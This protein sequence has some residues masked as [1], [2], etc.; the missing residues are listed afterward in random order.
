VAA[1]DQAEAAGGA[2]PAAPVSD[3]LAMEMAQ[4]EFV[5]Q[6]GGEFTLRGTLS[7]DASVQEVA[8]VL[9]D[10]ARQAEVGP[11]GARARAHAR[12]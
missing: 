11:P 9:R 8:A 5:K 3:A 10:Y 7:V 2:P 1:H 4:A 12:A 6:E